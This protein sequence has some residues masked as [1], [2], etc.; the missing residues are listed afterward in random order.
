MSAKQSNCVPMYYFS[1]QN[2]M[3][4]LVVDVASIHSPTHSALKTGKTIRRCFIAL[5]ALTLF[6]IIL[7]IIWLETIRVPLLTRE[8]RGI[9]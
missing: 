2:G 3:K 1:L 5:L 9:E 4:N 7:L 6:I 8:R